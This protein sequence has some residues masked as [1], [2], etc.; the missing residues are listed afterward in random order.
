MTVTPMGVCVCVEYQYLPVCL[1]VCIRS[2]VV[3]G[4]EQAHMLSLAVI[5]EVRIDYSMLLVY[6]LR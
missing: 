1:C 6:I 4:I 2:S 3:L 5:Y